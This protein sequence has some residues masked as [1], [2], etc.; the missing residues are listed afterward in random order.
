M[1]RHP[2]VLLLALA[3]LA[4]T[5][6]DKASQPAATSTPRP[7]P[8]PVTVA[9]EPAEGFTLADPAL[10]PLP[11]ARVDS[12]RLAGAVYRIEIPDDWNGRL[13]MF[14]GGHEF[15]PEL[16]AHPPPFRAWLVNRGYAWASSSLSVNR[17]YVSGV[18]ADETA[19]LWDH[20]AAR[21]GRPDRTY[22][23]GV[24]MG[25][26]ATFTAAE[27]YA[28]RFDG[29]V[30]LCGD[31]PPVDWQGDLYVI[32]AYAAG[33]TQQ[34]FD[35]L[36]AGVVLQHHVLPALDDPG[37]WQRFEDLWLDRT[38]GP[39]PF[40]AQGL[41]QA[42]GVIWAYA[43]SN[44]V[45]AYGNES[46]TYQLG[47]TAGVSSEEFNRGVIRVRPANPP[48]QYEEG[49]AV[50]GDLQVPLIAI[51]TTGDV[52]TPFSEIQSYARRVRDAG[53]QDLL[54]TRAIREPRHC[55]GVLI[56]EIGR[57]IED[58]EGWIEEGVKPAGEDLL[59]DLTAVGAD[60]TAAPRYGSPEAD[61]V[62]GAGDR[63]IV[64]G[65]ITVDGAP[66]EDG[67]L[68]AVVES[69]GALHNCSY[70]FPSLR[71]GGY[72]LAVAADSELGGCIGAASRT[73][74]VYLSDGRYLISEQQLPPAG[75][76]RAIAFDA[77]FS[78]ANSAGGTG[79]SSFEQYLGG[80]LIGELRLQD[81]RPAPPGTVVEAF[82]GDVLCGRFVA[83]PVL[84]AFDQPGV[85][86]IS[87]GGAGNAACATDVP[88]SLY[89]N[90]RDTGFTASSHPEDQGQLVNLTVPA[91]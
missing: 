40:G 59:G 29:A 73:F 36:G 80:T 31:A 17:Y 88:V 85:Y 45:D 46:K 62:P 37:A 4:A 11:G 53:K 60:F 52:Q 43:L 13:V 38:G 25:G 77:T 91:S 3:V 50:T 67:F 42:P 47:P 6:D 84:M 58:L 10:D 7:L 14:I 72:E 16:T 24:S 22:V 87:L 69:D 2:G 44:V 51:Q 34:Q 65:A 90:G 19:A 79:A 54:V 75:A 9:E 55:E 57:A 21:Y 28:D 81:G 68:W 70:G 32:A 64:R 48:S 33:V 61:A 18:A 71:R 74:L 1:L 63:V 82:V 56:D 30:A 76:E 66:V 41:R 78:S 35:E 12:G 8:S 5:C 27:R 15:G 23:T 89:V 49:N 39:R 86:N 20:F 26:A 83:P